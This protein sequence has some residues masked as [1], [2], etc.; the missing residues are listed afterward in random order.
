M[1]SPQSDALLRVVHEGWDHLRKQRPLAAWACWQNVIR[2]DPEHQAAL[3][4]LKTLANAPTLP[5]I[6]K[7][8]LRFRSPAANRRDRWSQILA[9]GDLSDL[10]AASEVFA[11]LAENDPEDS[12]ASYNRALCLAWQGR[13]RAAIAALDQVVRRSAIDN[14]EGAIDAWSVAELLR[15]GGGAEDLADDLSHALAIALDPSFDGDPSGHAIEDWIADLAAAGQLR[16]IDPRSGIPTSASP[17]SG[18]VFE[19]LDRP[20]PPPSEDLAPSQLP[21]VA[22]ILIR[23]PDG[24]RLSSPVAANLKRIESQLPWRGER[25]STPLPLTMLDAAAWTFRMPAGLDESTQRWLASSAVAQYYEEVWTAQ[26]RHGLKGKTPAE[27][28]K[29]SDP[30]D[31]IRL[32]AI[33]R[34]REQVAAASP[35]AQALEVSYNFERLRAR[36]GLQA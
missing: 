18:T 8:T 16:P 12:A 30:G 1:E 31:R 5:A 10:D 7:S 11:E 33:V 3:S 21:W 36:L 2:A 6:A 26:P 20:M 25:L 35:P 17:A 13:N 15:Q 28:G 9:G 19:W 14:S 32:E 27:A 4:A 22:A 24:L 23:T 34:F 29:S